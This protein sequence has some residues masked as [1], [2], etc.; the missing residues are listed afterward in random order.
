LNIQSSKS[1]DNPNYAD[2]RYT[3]EYICQKIKRISF[4]EEERGCD[5]STSVLLS[6]S[7]F[8]NVSMNTCLDVEKVVYFEQ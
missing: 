5:L 4:I 6:L 2:I 1:K 3:K 7:L 8:C